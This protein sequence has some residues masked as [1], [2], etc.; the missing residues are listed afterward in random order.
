[1]FPYIATYLLFATILAIVDRLVDRPLFI[2]SH[3]KH[4]P[5]KLNY[6]FR[7]W[8]VQ[9]CWAA[10]T[11]LSMCVLVFLLFWYSV[12]GRLNRDLAQLLYI[13][14]AVGSTVIATRHF[15]LVER[16]RSNAWW[17]TLLAALPTIALG[18]FANA[19]A[20]SYILNLTRIDAAK[21]PLAQK[22]L[23]ILFLVTLWIFVGVVLLNVAVFL[24]SIF[25]AAKTPTFIGLAKRHP[26]KMM[27]WRKHALGS[28]E[29]RQRVMLAIIF[30]GSTTTATIALNF[31]QYIGRHTE[32]ALQETLVFSS[33]HLHPRDCGIP[34]W[35]S[36]A[37]VAL[38]DDNKAVLAEKGVK[39]YSFKT[40]TCDLQTKESLKEGVIK[41]LKMDDYQ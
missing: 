41:R 13:P 5:W 3:L 34:G 17:I 15:R 4:F 9:E 2:R 16:F 38:I 23:A 21:F 14:I 26:V 20:D 39:G 29:K 37:W 10:V 35:T 12:G 6:S 28:S 19:Y 27:A 18:I 22:A 30:G 36:D 32:E 7:W 31:L 8:G 25:I 40:V 24:T 33:F 1:M 11:A